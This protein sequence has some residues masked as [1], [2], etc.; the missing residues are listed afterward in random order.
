MSIQILSEFYQETLQPQTTKQS[1]APRGQDTGHVIYSK[2]SKI[3]ITF[4]Y[5]FSNKLLVFRTGIHKMLVRI[6]NMEDPDQT[7]SL[8]AV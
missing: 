8:E 2:C 4:Q 7:A 5:L 6:A 3:S 1:M